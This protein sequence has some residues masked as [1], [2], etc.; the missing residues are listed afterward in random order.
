MMMFF[1]DEYET[2]EIKTPNF[3]SFDPKEGIFVFELSK[4]MKRMEIRVAR[5]R[6][7]R[8]SFTNNLL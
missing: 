8:F 7:K 3:V 5:N 1:A 2:I 6:D 4:E